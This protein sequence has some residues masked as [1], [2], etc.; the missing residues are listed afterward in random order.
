MN[1]PIERWKSVFKLSRVANKNPIRVNLL[2]IVAWSVTMSCWFFGFAANDPV[3][4]IKGCTDEMASWRIHT[5]MA[6]FDNNIDRS[7]LFV[8]VAFTSTLWT[9]IFDRR[10]LFLTFGSIFL[11]VHSVSVYPSPFISLVQR[12]SNASYIWNRR[13]QQSSQFV[14]NKNKNK[15]QPPSKCERLQSIQM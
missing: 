14:N 6:R 12:K 15:N 13:R 9:S 7:L 8:A 5:S 4:T 10:L 2:R 3:F 11:R 1:Q